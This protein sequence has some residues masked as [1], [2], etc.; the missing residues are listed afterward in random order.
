MIIKKKP[1]RGTKRCI[2]FG[3]VD[4]STVGAKTLVSAPAATAADQGGQVQSGEKNL[5]TGTDTCTTLKN[6]QE[7]S[8][9]YKNGEW[10]KGD[11]RQF[12]SFI[13]LPFPVK[14]VTNWHVNVKFSNVVSDIEVWALVFIS[15][16]R[17]FGAKH[18]TV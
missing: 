2:N 15:P 8:G 14:A 18:C 10:D 6:E 12:N 17:L 1:K 11:G 3:H 4:L 9:V 7:K 16:L 5:A 13:Y